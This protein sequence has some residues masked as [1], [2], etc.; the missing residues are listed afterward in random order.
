[1]NANQ[2]TALYILSGS[3]IAA[4]SVWGVLT[5]DQ[6]TAI[7]AVVN[8]LLGAIM[9]FTAVKNITPDEPPSE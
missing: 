9:A 3:I 4:L 1:M 2:R 5:N 7:L 8:G 6:G